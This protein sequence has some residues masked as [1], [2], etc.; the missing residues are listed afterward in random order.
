MESVFAVLRGTLVSRSKARRGISSVIALL[1]TFVLA[2]A[3]VHAA[4][5]HHVHLTVADTKA[6][7]EWYGKYLEGE[8]TVTAGFDTAKFGD[9]LVRFRQ[10]RGEV[11][12]TEGSAVDHI[13]FSFRDLDAKMKQF[14][15]AG[16]KIIAQPRQLGPIKFAFIEDPWGTKIEVMQDPDLYGFHHI[17]L[18]TPDP[19]ATLAF[20]TAQF[21]GEATRYGGFLP[22]IRYGDMWLIAQRNATEK[23]GTAGRVVDHLGWGFTDFNEAVARMKA[24]GV[25]FLLEPRESGDHHIAFIEGPSG[26]KIE[27][28]ELAG[29]K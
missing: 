10:A 14:A 26:V 17:H 6:G 24:D 22:A 16:I 23:P 25:K 2:T 3:S 28:Y 1:F 27:V 13:G 12:G 5:W 20:Y 19:D 11:K 9:A 15:D 21:G 4:S 18:H 7:A 29:G 8:V